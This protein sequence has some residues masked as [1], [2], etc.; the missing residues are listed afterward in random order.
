MLICNGVIHP[1]DAPVIPR[2]FVSF[3]EGIIRGVGPMEECP[4]PDGP[5]L[6]AQGGHV[7]PGLVD[8]HCHLGLFGDALGEAGEDCNE[9]TDPCTPQLRAADAV[10]PLDRCFQDA[11]AAGVTAVLTGPGSANPISGQFVAMKTSGRWVEEMVLQ[12]PA[13]M[14]F[15]LGE[16]PRA[17]YRRRRESPVTRMAT[18]AL[19]RS[20]LERARD[21]RERLERWAQGEGERPGRDEK[22]EACCPCCGG[23]S[24]SRSTPTAPTT[25][26]PPC[27]CAG[28]LTCAASSSTAPRPTSSPTCSGTPVSLSS[29]APV[30]GTAPSRSWPT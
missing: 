13:A 2:G 21:Y 20:A 8:A 18:A 17:A 29:P 22:L 7:L 5:V 1:M 15:S 6:D 4:S 10:N 12:A 23:R 3:S 28:N 19:I 25:L 9:D 27:A 11:R 26:P 14:K 30:W 16:N 24:P